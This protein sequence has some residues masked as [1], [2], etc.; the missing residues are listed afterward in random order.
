M[1]RLA[2]ALLA[3][4]AGAPLSAQTPLAFG[5]TVA[6]TLGAGDPVAEDDSWYDEYVFSARHG[7]RVTVTLRSEDFDA[8]LSL[9]QLQDG[10]WL[11][12]EG[13]D[14]GAGGTDSR[15]DATLVGDGTFLIRANT[16]SAGESGRYTLSLA[17]AEAPPAGPAPTT[18]AL[19]PGQS[20]TGVL[21][22]GDAVAA[23]DSWF[24][25]YSLSGTPGEPLTIE[26]RSADFDAWLTV[27]RMDDG[28]W[29]ETDSDDDGAGG[30]DARVVTTLPASGTLLV[31][32][33]TLVAGENGG[34]TLT[35]ASGGAAA[36]EAAGCGVPEGGSAAAAAWY[37]E[38]R[39]ISVLG[40]SWV[41]YGLPR[42]LA[43]G[44][45]VQAAEFLFVPLYV[46]V[47]ARPPY[48]VLY[49]PVG[50]CAFQPYVPD[51]G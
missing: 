11:L 20:V 44:E 7:Q 9:G 45:V 47:A 25:L 13:N 34:Y 21:G 22:A 28:A 36:P 35:V 23:D 41:K 27:G 38:G 6:G 12:L 10:E 40:R 51:G 26:L 49:A 14:D 29:V 33:N 4:A 42:E 16:L 18:V 5:Q 50:G 31:R 48:E 17:A 2:L 1:S 30:T 8:Y 19:R 15:V 37:E 3:L 43:P 32:A 24:D 46:E 39:P